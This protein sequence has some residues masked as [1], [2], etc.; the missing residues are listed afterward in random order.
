MMRA[1]HPDVVVVGAGVVGAACALA[2]ARE[3]QRVLIVDADFPGGGSTGVAMGHI[4]VMDDS[5]A[6]LALTAYSRSLWSEMAG[7]LPPDCEDERRGTLW[8]ATTDEELRAAGQKQA[9]YARHGVAASVV[10]AAALADMEPHLRP[11]LAGALHVPDDSVL[12]PPAAAR[13]FVERACSLGAEVL[14]R[15]TVEEI[16]DGTVS[17]ATSGGSLDTVTAGAVVNAAGIDAPRLTPGLPIIP[18]KG[19]L[20]ITE[21]YPGMCSSQLVELGYLHSAHTMEGESVAFNVQP[22]AT[23]QLL[24]GSSRE[25]VGRDRRINHR[26]LAAMLQ[27]A[28]GFLPSLARCATVRAWTGFRPATPDKLP[29]IGRWDGDGGERLWIAAG[30]EGLGITMALG[31]AELLVSQMLGTSAPVDPAPFAPGRVMPG[32]TCCTEH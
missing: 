30:H 10:D 18:R 2:L 4:V 17:L 1:G 3:H 26:L 20:V 13:Y 7:E 19:H 14:E 27:R 9:V 8:L 25:L 23:G 21:R 24:I 12:Y 32:T 28:I 15:C 22:R 11:G 31:T 5:E 6:Q 29:L 16:G